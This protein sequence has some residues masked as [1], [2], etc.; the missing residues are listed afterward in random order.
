[1]DL[2][3]CFGIRLFFNNRG[4]GPNF[5]STTALFRLL[6]IF[7]ISNCL[8]TLWRGDLTDFSLLLVL[9]FLFLFFFFPALDVKLV[10]SIH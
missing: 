10:L 7:F 9:T 1:M 3:S 4:S 2:N 6:L 5:N 8:A